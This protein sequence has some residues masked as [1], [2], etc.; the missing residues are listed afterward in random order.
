MLK[1]RLDFKLVNL[2]VLLIL[3]FIVFELRIMFLDIFS[4]FI[5]IIKP[6]VIS[7]I[8]SYILNCFLRKLNRY[9]NK[10]ISFIIIILILLLFGYFICFKVLPVFVLEVSE[11]LKILILFFRDMSIKYNINIIDLYNKVVGFLPKL[12]GLINFNFVNY[13]LDY[14][15]FI[16]VVVICSIYLFF[17]FDRMCCSV[18]KI[19]I[20]Y[21][22][23]YRFLVALNTE[24]E[25]Y[26]SSFF[27][28]TVINVFEYMFVF[29]IIGHPNY[30]FLGV[31]AGIL[32]IIPYFGGIITNCCALITGFVFNYGLFIRTL[33][34]ILVLSI[35]DGYVVSPFV[36]SKGSKLHPILIILSVY[37]SSQFLGILGVV[38]SV[39]FLVFLSVFYKFYIKKTD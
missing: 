12:N 24:L 26:I 32:S 37:V 36:Y 21:N 30:L 10:Y 3:V 13:I 16:S 11:I 25:K 14:F 31:M 22:K 27:V 34:G 23:F 15:T 33:I 4:F 29:Y 5:N 19:S 17:D 18:K 2:L 1:N 38:L 20:K 28:L 6:F 7:L 8:I 9:F 39:P 35:V